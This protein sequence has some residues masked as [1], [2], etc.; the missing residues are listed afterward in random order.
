MSQQNRTYD[1]NSSVVYVDPQGRPHSA[2]I[3]AWWG[4]QS[5]GT[6]EEHDVY[7]APNHAYISETGEPGCNLVYLS[8]DRTKTDP[9]GRQIERA[10]SVVH[11]SKQAAPGNYWLWPDETSF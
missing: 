8:G 6:K 1:H 10:T 4:T 3:T 5:A 2:I 7:G 11:K 9:Y